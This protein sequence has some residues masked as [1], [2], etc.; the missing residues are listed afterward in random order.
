MLTF[1]ETLLSYWYV[2][3]ACG[4]DWGDDA[5]D[6]LPKCCPNCHR[7]AAAFEVVDRDQHEGSGPQLQTMTDRIARPE[8][9]KVVADEATCTWRVLGEC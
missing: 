6:N 8:S 4:H 1:A 9:A 3:G 5:A 7:Q 2:C